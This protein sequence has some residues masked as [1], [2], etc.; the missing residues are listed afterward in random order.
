MNNGF[1]FCFKED[2]L[3]TTIG[4]DIEHNKFCRQESIF[5]KVTSNRDGDLLSQFDNIN[6]N[7]IPTLERL[8]DLPPQFKSTPHQKML[9]NNHNDSNKGK[10]KRYFYLE[11][12][13]GFCKSFKKITK[14]LEFHL[15]LKTTDLEDFLYTSVADDINVTIKNLYLY[16]PNL[17]PNVETHLM[18]NEAT[19]NNCW[20]SYEEWYT[21]RRLISDMIS[22][23][24]VRSA[25]Q[26]NI[27]KYLI[28][29]H[30]TRNRIDNRNKTIKI[31]IFDNLYHRKYYVK[32][33]EQ[34]YPRDSVL[35]NYTESEHTGHYKNL[36]L[37][38]KEY[39][40]EPILNPL[41]S[42]PDMKTKHPIGITDL[43][44]QLDHIT[45]KRIQI[46]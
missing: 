32:I 24:D 26:V 1:A 45:P 38:F 20:I 9:S 41:I 2:R 15:M 33:D 34:R 22:Q 23:V 28:S 3:S 18:F 6:E 42:Y 14:K 10:I 19:Q 7:D 31:A 17:I 36:Y 27:P 46:F 40:G 11:G 21:E 8:A 39:V 12:F 37:Y 44:R 35:T 30:Q 5:L 43:R 25:Q 13:S 4:K 16:K 29:A